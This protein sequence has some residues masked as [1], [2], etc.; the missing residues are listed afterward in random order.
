MINAILQSGKTLLSP[1]DHMP[2]LNSRL[3]LLGSMM[4][5]MDDIPAKCVLCWFFRGN[6]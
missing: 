6:K 4:P 3:C 5:R 2:I 1:A